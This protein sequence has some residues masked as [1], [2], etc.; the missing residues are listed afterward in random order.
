MGETKSPDGSFAEGKFFLVDEK[1]RMRINAATLT[2][3]ESRFRI[4]VR[5]VLSTIMS[6]IAS[7]QCRQ[8]SAARLRA[9]RVNASVAQVVLQ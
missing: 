3:N 6:N 8:V 1:R 2:V 4:Q 5:E 9:L 7:G